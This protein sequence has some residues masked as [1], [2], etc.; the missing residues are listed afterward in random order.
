MFDPVGLPDGDIRK[1]AAWVRQWLGFG[2]RNDYDTYRQAVERCGIL[3]FGP[4]GYKGPWQLAKE[5]PVAGF[6]LY[7]SRCP[8]I[9]VKKTQSESRR[10]FTLM[11]ELAHVLLHRSSWIDEPSDLYAHD[12]AQERQ[13]NQLAG[14]VLV[15]PE[16]LQHIDLGRLPDDVYQFD[17]YFKPYTQRW[18]VSTEVILRRLM[19]EG[20]LS[21]G[22]YQAYRNTVA[23]LGHEDQQGGSRTYRHREPRHL[24]GDRYVRAV[25]DSLSAQTI[26][27]TK[28]SAYLNGIGVKDVHKLEQFCARPHP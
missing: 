3:V 18:R 8:V 19:D 2:E 5:S 13:A 7:D 4:H 10:C 14:L 24:F 22:T 12:V 23:D 15:P 6:S 21:P 11:H 28:A 25:L 16:F 9:V 17:T 26:T 1:A 20:R 27:L